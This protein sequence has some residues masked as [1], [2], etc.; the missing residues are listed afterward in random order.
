MTMGQ[1]T[2]TLVELG[3]TIPVVPEMDDLT[4]GKPYIIPHEAFVKEDIIPIQFAYHCF[5][6]FWI[7]QLYYVL[8]YSSPCFSEHSFFINSVC[9]FLL[10]GD[11]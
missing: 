5:I 11:Q 10:Y 1:L 8:N 3:W 4:V 9:I 2:H 7:H 6:N